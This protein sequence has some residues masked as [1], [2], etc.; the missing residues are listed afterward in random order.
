MDESQTDTRRRGSMIGI[1]LV[2]IGL[3]FTGVGTYALFSDTETNTPS[4]ETE[5]I[6]LTNDTTLSFQTS[7]ILP[8]DNG[9]GSVVLNTTGTSPGGDLNVSIGNVNDTDVVAVSSEEEDEDGTNVPLSAE[10]E[11]KMWMEEADG[12]A[13]SS[14]SF[15]VAEDYGLH[16][17]GSVIHGSGSLA[18]ADLDGFPVGS[19]YTTFNF[20]SD[21]TDKEFYV[22]WQLPS[23]TNNSVQRDRTEV[24]YNFTI[25]QT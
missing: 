8:G 11:V 13:G 16:H 25:T 20:T 1:A 17:N 9:S 15:D 14:G 4:L 2:T 21:S 7:N 12:G 22:E 3:A 23:A 19:Q 18:F 5:S 24:Q 10:L 6:D